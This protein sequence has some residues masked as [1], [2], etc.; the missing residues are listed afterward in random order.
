MAGRNQKYVD[1][2]ETITVSISKKVLRKLDKAVSSYEVSRSEIVNNILQH[3]FVNDLEYVRMMAK[4]HN[5][6]FQFWLSEMKR[7]ENEIKEGL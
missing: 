1:G 2:V 5:R 3:H 4:E 6:K 7:V